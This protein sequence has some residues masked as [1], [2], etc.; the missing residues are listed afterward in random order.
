MTNP[1]ASLRYWRTV[2]R[3]APRKLKRS[4]VDGAETVESGGREESARCD[5][6]AAVGQA[7][8][9]QEFVADEEP[10]REGPQQVPLRGDRRQIVEGQPVLG[11][12]P[13]EDCGLVGGCRPGATGLGHE[14]M[15]VGGGEL[16]LRDEARQRLREWRGGGRG[17]HAAASGQESDGHRN[18]LLPQVEDRTQF[19]LGG[20]ELHLVGLAGGAQPFQA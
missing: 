13:A 12:E 14:A 16:L 18:G 11:G 5:L 3:G 17:G 10:G 7:A 2:S 8:Q 15:R 6:H 9:R 4:P 1:A 20:G 19:L